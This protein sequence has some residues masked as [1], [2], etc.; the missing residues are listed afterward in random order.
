MTTGPEIAGTLPE[1]DRPI[2]LFDGV[3]NLCN[4]FVRTIIKYDKKQRFR[5]SSLQ[6]ETGQQVVHYIEQ[7]VGSVPDSLI[8]LYKGV[9]YTRSGAVLMT[10]KLLGGIWRLLMVGYGLPTGLRDRLYGFVASH[11]YKWFGKRDECMVPTPEL[12]A[13]FLD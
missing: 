7:H 13:R 6:S 4:G 3:C 8:L 2:L 1:S 5:F 10:A 11:R 12:M 9:Y